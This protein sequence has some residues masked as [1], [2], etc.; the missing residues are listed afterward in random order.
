MFE[1]L[2][3]LE[4]TV[5][6]R[7]PLLMYSMYA[8]VSLLFLIPEVRR[9]GFSQPFWPVVLAATFLLSLTWLVATLRSVVPP[10]RREVRVRYVE[11]DLRVRVVGQLVDR[12]ARQHD[13]ALLLLGGDAHR[14]VLRGLP[15]A[16][17]GGVGI[18]G[19]GWHDHGL[20]RRRHRL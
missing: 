14:P 11:R 13:L 3:P 8:V 16:D 20:L 9:H 17:R 10:T 2:D 4:R 15:P 6:R 19:A 18:R 5:N 7:R 12:G 1:S